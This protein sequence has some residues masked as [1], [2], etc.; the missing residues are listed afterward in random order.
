MI[1]LHSH[2]TASD[3]EH[4]PRELIR[5][6]AEAG[7]RTLAVTDHDTVAGLDEAALAAREMGVRLVRGIEL[8]CELNGREVHIL[9]HFVDSASGAIAELAEQMGR[10]RR[11]RMEKMVAKLAAL[12]LPVTMEA[13]LAASGGGS[14]G[15]PHLARVLV[16]R[17]LAADVKDA[18][19]RYL[20]AG[21]PGYVERRRLA[22][23][24]G[25]SLA[26]AAGGVATVAHPGA[27]KISRHELAALATVGLAGVEAD[28]PDH[29]PSQ[30]EAY[31]RWGE[32]LGLVAT[33]GSDYH[34]E[35]VT[36]DR[37]LGERTMSDAALAALEARRQVATK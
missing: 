26:R 32:E 30:V 7:V 8:S 18:F 4:A 34:G 21:T 17:G 35:R 2:T 6:A 24:E 11:A 1:D 23:A 14:I 15:R 16:D 9:G 20:K 36:P 37:R 5:R 25:I 19:A 33:A 31:A 13:V 12:G 28:H 3:G 27:S 22:A 10:E 29:V